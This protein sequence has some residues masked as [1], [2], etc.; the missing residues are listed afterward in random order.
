M[1]STQESVA[2][3]AAKLIEICNSVS[4]AAS[5]IIRFRGD[6]C[7]IEALETEL[8]TFGAMINIMGDCSDIDLDKCDSKIMS[9]AIS[10][11]EEMEAEQPHSY[12][13]DQASDLAM[14][15]AV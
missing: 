2:F 9:Q 10:L 14:R 7:S 13:Q 15:L 6:K 12:W 4:S 1:S 5:E 8:N 11:K 3:R